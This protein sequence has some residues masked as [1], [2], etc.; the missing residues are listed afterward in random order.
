M[1]ESHPE[2]FYQAAPLLKLTARCR[3]FSS[4][5]RLPDLGPLL[6]ASQRLE[7]VH[8]RRAPSR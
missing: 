7:R 2:G 5:F 3:V 4:L 8:R 1:R 6:F